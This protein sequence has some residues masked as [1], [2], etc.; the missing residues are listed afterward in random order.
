MR[1][2]GVATARRDIARVVIAY[3]FES[4]VRFFVCDSW[5]RMLMVL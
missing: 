5:F 3:M 2:A 4:I 1:G